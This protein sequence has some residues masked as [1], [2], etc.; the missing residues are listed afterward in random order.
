M[1]F[2][3]AAER[4]KIRNIIELRRQLEYMREKASIC[5]WRICIWSVK[6]F[7]MPWRWKHANEVIADAKGALELW[8]GG[9]DVLKN[10]MGVSV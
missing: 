2:A 9:I 8:Q 5:K 10:T 6:R 1:E 4:E 3:A 7:I